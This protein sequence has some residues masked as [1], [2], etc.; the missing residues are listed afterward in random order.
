MNPQFHLYF[1]SVLYH[2]YH[3]LKELRKG[4]TREIPCSTFLTLDTMHILTTDHID[5]VLK[6]TVDKKKA[7]IVPNT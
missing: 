6:D 3:T 7:K 5:N 4:V 2:T 1:S